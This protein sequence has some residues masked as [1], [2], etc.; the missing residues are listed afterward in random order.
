MPNPFA[1]AELHTTEP[2]TTREFYRSLFDWGLETKETPMGP[3]TE[4]D[5]REGFPGGLMQSENG[6]SIWVPYVRVDDLEVSTEKAKELGARALYEMAEVPD[7]GRITVLV[8]PAGA[9]FGLWQP[10]G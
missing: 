5:T 7:V 10:K 3:Y 1:Y 2:G 8:D 6:S 4:I 9:T